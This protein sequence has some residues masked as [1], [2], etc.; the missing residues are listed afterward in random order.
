MAHE[1]TSTRWFLRARKGAMYNAAVFVMRKLGVLG[2]D[3]H[4]DGDSTIGK[5]AFMIS[6][7]FYTFVTVRSRNRY[8]H[9]AQK[10][11]IYGMTLLMLTDDSCQ[12]HVR[13]LL[14]SYLLFAL[15]FRND[16]LEW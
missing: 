5:I 2:P 7:L 3:E 4:P 13:K 12:I 14:C 9:H 1:Q 11:L 6:Q 10:C 16:H 15:Y 8:F